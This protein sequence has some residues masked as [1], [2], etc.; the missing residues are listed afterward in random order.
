MQSCVSRRG[1]RETH[2]HMDVSFLPHDGVGR[3]TLGREIDL[4][5]PRCRQRRGKAGGRLD[6]GAP[7][8]RCRP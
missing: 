1:S 6:D 4:D 7:D 5:A 2:E 3:S 8:W